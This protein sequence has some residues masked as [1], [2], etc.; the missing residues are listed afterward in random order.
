MKALVCEAFGPP[1]SLEVKD[2]DVPE[3]GPGEVRIRV[4]AAGVNFPDALIIEGKYQFRPPFPF[5][6]GGEASGTID[7]VGEGVLHLKVGQPVAAL[8][9]HGAFA[10]YVVARASQT[11]VLPDAMD[12][13]AA[14]GV[15][16]AYGT[17]HYALKQ[18]A[19]L[20]GGETVLVLGAAGGTGLAAV[21]LAKVMGARVIA[22]A[23]SDEKLATAREHGA[24]ET[25]NYAA[26][27]LREEI[28]RT[29]GGAGPDVIYDP[30][31]GDLTEP[32]FRSIAWGGRHL[33]VG[34]AA[35]KVPSLALNL[36]L[37]KGASL[38]GVF[39]GDFVQ[40]QPQA[41]Q[42]NMAELLQWCSDG[43]I[44]PAVTERY[45]LERGAEAIRRLVNRQARGKIVLLPDAA[46]P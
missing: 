26:A 16:L 30:V 12:L 5:A 7:A 37:L 32:A 15:V 41:N 22:A 9:L 17:S 34:F 23:S 24:D 39:W 20:R 6:P 45:P 42:A 1:E 11:F 18:R 36:P 10:Q 44:R 29:T 4:A 3:P 43:R 38:V 31:G 8:T 2:I 33:V 21:Q 19:E 13:V 35:G 27:D 40:R 25:I 14:G 28:R 46:G